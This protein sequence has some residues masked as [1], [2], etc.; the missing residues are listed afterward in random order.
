LRSRRPGTAAHLALRERQVRHCPHRHRVGP[1]QNAEI[2]A[3]VA[4]AVEQVGAPGFGDQRRATLDD[5]AILTGAMVISADL[6]IKLENVTLEDL[7][8]ADRIVI[9][10]DTTMIIGGRGKAVA[11]EQRCDEIRRQ[12]KDTTSN[13]DKD[14]L[15]ERLA[16]LSG[17]IA[18]NRCRRCVRGRV[19]AARGSVR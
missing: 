12:I 1:Q 5:I 9:D 8:S 2:G 18:V 15:E 17:G 10:K 14:K 3:L 19:E 11:V 13:Y 6:G 4:D 7:G 16:K